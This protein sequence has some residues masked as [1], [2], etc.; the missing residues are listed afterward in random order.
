MIIF[1]SKK[2]KLFP[3]TFV[4]III[5]ILLFKFSK[6]VKTMFYSF[7][8]FNSPLTVIV[9]N[10]NNIELKNNNGYTIGGNLSSHSSPI[11]AVNFE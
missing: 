4:F 11:V 7:F 1:Y 9:N 3:P 10:N 5:I 6:N 2:K 8:S